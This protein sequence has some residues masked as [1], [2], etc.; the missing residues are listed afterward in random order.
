MS[1]ILNSNSLE[2]TPSFKKKSGSTL[3]YINSYLLFISLSAQ[4]REKAM[5]W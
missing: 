4:L 1:V 2:R 3:L 5:L